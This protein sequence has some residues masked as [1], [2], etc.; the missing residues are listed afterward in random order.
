MK[1]KMFSCDNGDFVSVFL[2]LTMVDFTGPVWKAQFTLDK[3]TGEVLGPE[4]EFSPN[5]CTGFDEVEL[6]KVPNWCRVMAAM[7]P[8]IMKKYFQKLI[9]EQKAKQRRA[10]P[11]K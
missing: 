7:R 10:D 5:D 9:D 11:G 1:Y 8:K 3:S 4:W 6:D 2:D